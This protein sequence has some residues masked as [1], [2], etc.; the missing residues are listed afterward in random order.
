MSNRRATARSTSTVG[1]RAGVGACAAIAASPW[2]RSAH[3][4]LVTVTRSFMPWAG[5]TAAP[6]GLVAA[7]ARRPRTAAA[8]LLVG[9]AS[10]AMCWPLVR[11]RTAPIARRSRSL[12]IV[13]VNLLS[14]NRH[15]VEVGDLLAALAAD[16]VTFSEYTPHHA[17]MLRT[18]GLIT[19]CP[20]R[21]DLVGQS[22]TGTA[23]WSRFPVTLRPTVH[24]THHTVVADVEAPTG[25]IQVIVVHAQSPIAHH[26]D[27]LA[28]LARLG[29]LRPT[30]P[31][32]L[33]GDFNA[34]WWHPEFRALLASTW[35]DSHIA[36]GR[37]LSCSWP[38]E[39]WHLLFRWHP[40]FTRLDHALVTADLDVI[41]VVDLA[42]PGSDHLGLRVTVAISDRARR[43][44]P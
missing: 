25:R 18:T 38:T 16:V 37:G 26:G 43:A 2:L 3:G 39:K 33:T 11:R 23:L 14:V 44:T 41:E 7:F 8:G 15:V 12:S 1:L 30:I 24:T 20:H 35:R 13:H 6:L 19:R 31:T 36:R 22:S 40:P 28:D 34:G 21:L 29:D 4:R 42:I 10:A 27:W 17:T 32:V 9:A 5:M